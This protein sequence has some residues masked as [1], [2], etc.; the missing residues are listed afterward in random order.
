MIIHYSRSYGRAIVGPLYD[1]VAYLVEGLEYAQLWQTQGWME[2]LERMHADPPHSPFGT[3]V[4][5]VGFVIFGPVEWAAYAIMGLVVLLV[6]LA[7]DMLM[8][9]LP[10]HARVA[11]TL[12]ALSFPIT[13]TLVSD[14]RPDATAGLATGLGGVLML[15]WSPFLASRRRQLITGLC[16]A[17]ALLV[18][19]PTFVFTLYMFIGSWIVAAL[20]SSETCHGPTVARRGWWSALWPYCLP[21]LLLAGPY[22]IAVGARMVRY[23][24]E[25]VLGQNKEIWIRREPWLDL[26]RYIWDGP[27][28][29]L[30]I[31]L[32]GYVVAGFAATACLVRLCADPEAVWRPTF[33]NGVAVAGL[34]FLAWLMPTLS[35]YGNPF[36]GATYAAILLF[37]GVLCLRAVFLSRPRWSGRWLGHP[38]VVVIVGW[39]MVI[40]GLLAFHWPQKLGTKTTDWVVADNRIEREIYRALKEASAPDGYSGQVYVTGAATMNEHVLRFRALIDELPLRF[41]AKPYSANVTEH[42]AEIEK[43]DYVVAGDQGTFRDSPLPSYSVQGRILEALK[44]DGHLRQLATI[45]AYEGL[46]FYVFGR[47]PWFGGWDVATGLGSLEGPY[48]P[49]GNRMVRWGLGAVTTM[50]LTSATPRG[51]EVELAGLTFIPEQTIELIV[52]GSALARMSIDPSDGFKHAIF[53]VSLSAGLNQVEL[54]YKSW[55]HRANVPP[56]AVLFKQLRVN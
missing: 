8:R 26:A 3:L 2:C 35:R 29:Q 37:V 23:V 17:V 54:R 21:V 13:G 45:S 1:D 7:V 40:V 46:N 14:F 31:G 47:P 9:G 10:F 25:N 34:L 38:S 15:I 50:R 43:A 19:T 32:H 22:Y 4:A 6:M 11:G 28:G 27:G 24:Y 56:M 16:F 44:A 30:M 48:A 42:I 12:F 55:D 49:A 36:I 51:A 53:A 33:K 18:K 41:F 39:A 5:A 52:N 20:C